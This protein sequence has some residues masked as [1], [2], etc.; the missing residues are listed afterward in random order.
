M[1]LLDKFKFFSHDDKPKTVSSKESYR[2]TKF[3]NGDY[4]VIVERKLTNCLPKG[5]NKKPLRV[6]ESLWKHRSD[7]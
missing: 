5:W 3:K 7:K 2:I 4:E 1:G 6:Q